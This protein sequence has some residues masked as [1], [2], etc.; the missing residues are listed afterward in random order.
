MSAVSETQLDLRKGSLFFSVKKLSAGSSFEIK[1]PKAVAGVRGTLGWMNA[2]GV[3]RIIRG[4]MAETYRAP[5]GVTTKTQIIQAR[6]SFDPATGLLQGIPGD[7]HRDLQ[8]AVMDLIRGAGVPV[9]PTT[10]IIDPTNLRVSS[11]NEESSSSDSGGSDGS[12]D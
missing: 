1:C 9:L 12:R 4:I 5:D 6:Q 10:F 2:D 11:I 8:Q 7:S 3:I